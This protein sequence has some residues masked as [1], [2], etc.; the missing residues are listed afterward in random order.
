M[1]TTGC[2]HLRY[3]C[4]PVLAYSDCG[5]LRSESYCLLPEILSGPVEGVRF[6]RT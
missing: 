3:H 4:T 1:M 2:H 5:A 6:C